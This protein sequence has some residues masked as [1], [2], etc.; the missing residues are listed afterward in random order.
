MTV[1]QL[2]I[3][4]FKLHRF[5]LQLLSS[6]RSF[7]NLEEMVLVATGRLGHDSQHPWTVS[8]KV[9]CSAQKFSNLK[10]LE[11]G[12][13][14]LMAILQGIW[15]EVIFAMGSASVLGKSKVQL[16]DVKNQ[17]NCSRS[18]SVCMLLHV[19]ALP[20]S[21]SSTKPRWPIASLKT[22]VSD[23]LPPGLFRLFR[24]L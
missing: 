10:I 22:S 16:T 15:S 7:L 12:I 19:Y 3:S 11:R 14:V 24:D 9:S 21:G 6:E 17:S 8:R 18:G 5:L 4:N 20:L 1:L 2:L 23:K 13:F